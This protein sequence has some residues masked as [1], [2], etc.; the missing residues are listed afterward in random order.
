MNTSI[1]EE[2]TDKPEPLIVAPPS[3][4]E[5]PHLYIKNKPLNEQLSSGHL[6]AYMKRR[7]ALWASMS[8]IKVDH[9]VFSFADMPHLYPMY[10]DRNPNIRVMKAAQRGASVYMLLRASHQCLYPDSW[11]FNHPIKVGFYFPEKSG[12]SRLVKD[13]F[14]PMMHSC[15]DLMPWAN[16]QR[17]DMRPINDSTFYFLFMAGTSTKD[18][19]P[20]NSIFIDEVRLVSLDDIYQTY[21]RLFASKPYKWKCHVS[22]A[23]YPS[24]DIDYLFMD[25][26]Q[27][28]YYTTCEHCGKNQ[29]LS[30]DFP[31]CISEP[32]PHSTIQRWYYICKYCRMEIK[33]PKQG[34]YI[35]HNPG[36]DNSGYQ[37]S[38]LCGGLDSYGD[39]FLEPKD[40]MLQ[41]RSTKDLKEFYNSVVGV[42]FV[43]ENNRP[44]HMGMLPGFVNTMLDWGDPLG[45][46]CY[47][48]IDQM[49]GLNYVWIITRRGQKW[50]VVWF[51]IIEDND[52]FRR[53]G[54]LMEEFDVVA[55]ITDALPNANDALR[56][57]QDFEGKVFLAYYGEQSDPA[58]WDD[59]YHTPKKFKKVRKG[60]YSKYKVR[61]D[62]YKSYGRTLQAI[63]YGKVEWPEPREHIISCRPYNGGV[64][65][66]LPIMMT[67]AYP[68][69]VS[70]VREEVKKEE[71]VGGKGKKV[72]EHKIDDI[73][74]RWVFLGCDPHA[75][76][77][78]NNAIWAS[79]RRRK[80]FSFSM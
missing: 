29:I 39:W 44:V 46:D 40:V 7:L 72:S 6:R 3:E 15:P 32:A 24:S 23:G 57:A 50:R 52:P 64:A 21:A 35:A 70:A 5:A 19:V 25:S 37:F 30:E 8:G 59:D 16:E 54:Q 42:P 33:D 49:M 75:L 69:F 20:L 18:S 14:I 45:E 38:Q 9:K 61:F 17:Q 10:A 65:Q 36:H 48:G 80:S 47:M 77:S 66:P 34:L 56:F 13:R 11:G 73:K 68:H 28:W 12:V 58:I 60:T 51:E 31:D 2:T 79:E 41:Y 53:C 76:S 43:D 67:H 78:F 22:T 62:K 4:V 63:K 1:P 26:D 27:K 55:C 71:G 74:Y